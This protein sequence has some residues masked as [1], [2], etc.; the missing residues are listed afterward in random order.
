MEDTRPPVRE[1]YHR[2][3]IPEMYQP[4]RSDEA[5]TGVHDPIVVNWPL[6]GQMLAIMAA[7]GGFLIPLSIIVWRIAL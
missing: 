2:D 3:P 6:V 1:G 7:T 5:A 4:Q